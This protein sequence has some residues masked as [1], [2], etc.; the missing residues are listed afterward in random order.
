MTAYLI[1]QIDVQDPEAYSLYTARTPAVIA[2]FGGRFVVRGGNPE[3]LEGRLVGQRIVVIAFPERAA[4]ERF[5]RSP[6]Y[7]AIL[8]LR[9]AASTG[10]SCI[11]DGT[12]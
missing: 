9:L 7:Q 8:P 10:A 11:V 12:A 4:A 1:A 6:D 3:V 5:Y 2:Q